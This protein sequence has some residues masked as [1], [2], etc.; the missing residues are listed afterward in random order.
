LWREANTSTKG[1]VFLPLK[2][3]LEADKNEIQLEESSVKRVKRTEKGS[4]IL[5][6]SR[7]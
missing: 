3:S 7:Y 4:I 2:L 6:G 1:K 5:F